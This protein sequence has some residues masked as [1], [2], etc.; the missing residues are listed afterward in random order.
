MMDIEDEKKDKTT[1]SVEKV[2]HRRHGGEGQGVTG[3]N[4]NKDIKHNG[5][6]STKLNMTT[7]QNSPAKTNIKQEPKNSTTK[8]VDIGKGQER[9]SEGRNLGHENAERKAHKDFIS[10]VTTTKSKATSQQAPPAKDIIEKES[11]DTT[12]D[13]EMGEDHQGEGN[14]LEHANTDRQPHE[15][16]TDRTK[17]SAATLPLRSTSTPPANCADIHVYP[18]ANSVPPSPAHAM[19]SYSPNASALHPFIREL[20][21]RY[22]DPSAPFVDTEYPYIQFALT[23]LHACAPSVEDLI[24]ARR[25]CMFFRGRQ[26]SV[27]RM[28]PLREWI[29]EVARKE[30]DGQRGDGV[31]GMPKLEQLTDEQAQADIRLA[32]QKVAMYMAAEPEYVGDVCAE[33][34]IRVERLSPDQ[35]MVG[36]LQDN[37]GKQHGWQ[38]SQDGADVAEAAQAVAYDHTQ[39]ENQRVPKRFLGEQQRDD[40]TAAPP[41]KKLRAD[42]D[43][44]MDTNTTRKKI[45]P[46][47]IPL[48][49]ERLID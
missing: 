38:V 12:I 46:E 29:E 21:A 18:R 30:A 2:M 35:R 37:D 19:L 26:T 14:N 3:Q 43:T 24:A 22:N 39:E 33:L 36:E 44:D 32:V 17:P 28:G 41:A 15:S 49:M 5:V 45:G 31:A 40:D 16:R 11:M 7:H 25:L 48:G 20:L 4:E 10:N 42:A 9:E 34:G 6:A 1:K 27:W 13:I 47:C 8:A 23:Q